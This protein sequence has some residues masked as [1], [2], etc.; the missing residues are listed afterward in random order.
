MFR[1]GMKVVFVK[2]GLHVGQEIGDVGVIISGDTDSMYLVEFSGKNGP[3]TQ[4][5]VLED[6]IQLDT[7]EVLKSLKKCLKSEI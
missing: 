3:I 1:P 7:N 4:W 5:Y 2:E 6:Q